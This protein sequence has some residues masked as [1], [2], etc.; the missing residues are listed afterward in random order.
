VGT[1]M[2]FHPTCFEIYQ[3]LS[4]LHFGQVDVNGLMNWRNIFNQP[5]TWSYIPRDPAVDRGKDQEWCHNEGDESLAANPVFVP[6]LERILRSAVY[7]QPSFSPQGGAFV[8]PE[9]ASNTSSAIESVDPFLK[10][11]R[12]IADNIVEHLNSRE[13]ANMRLSSRAFRQL[14]ISL[15]YSLL[16]KE[17]PWVWEIW[18]DEKPSFWTSVSITDIIAEKY[19]RPKFE[20]ELQQY[21]SIIKEEMPQIFED[22]CA[23][24]PAFDEWAVTSRDM[25]TARTPFK[26][27]RSQTNW[28][29]LYRDI[30]ANWKNLK[31]LHNRRRI[32]KDSEEII[33][34]IKKLRAE[35]KIM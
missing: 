14:R 7:D 11:P 15:W 25:Y 16:K 27:P 9:P 21:R 4:R 2:P 20:A 17:M 34:R 12:E 30:T 8:I 3:R 22:W 33:S 28:Y 32:W 23:A 5:P 1:V 26:L 13:I 24:E 10:L 19:V 18:S 35:G 29:Q 31:G 6:A